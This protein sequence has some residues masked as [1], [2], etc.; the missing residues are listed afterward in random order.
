MAFWRGLDKSESEFADGT[1]HKD[2]M[3][4]TGQVAPEWG[5][6]LLGP[7]SQWRRSRI[8][9]KFIRVCTLRLPHSLRLLL[10]P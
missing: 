4:G 6:Q 2:R 8:P 3:Q 10:L 1:A 9:H 5:V 7:G